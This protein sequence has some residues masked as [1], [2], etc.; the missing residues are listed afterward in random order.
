MA[1]EFDDGVGLDVPPRSRGHVVDDLWQ[2]DGVRDR[3]VVLEQSALLG[4]VVVRRDEQQAVGTRVGG[5]FGE[6]ERLA[7]IVRSRPGDDGDVVDGLDD[8]LDDLYVFVVGQGRRL[9]G[10]AD[11]NES[12]DA[13]GS[14]RWA[15]VRSVSKSIRSASSKGVH[16]AGKTP[17][18]SRVELMCR[19][20]SWVASPARS[21][22]YRCRSA[23]GYWNRSCAV[24]SSPR[25]VAS[26]QRAHL[27]TFTFEKTRAD[28]THDG[29]GD[30]VSGE[31]HVRWTGPIRLI[32]CVFIPTGPR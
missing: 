4:L 12:V 6:F 1:R 25:R 27:R 21:A 15:S 14:R 8:R 16:I 22:A 11:G 18:R 26:P 2:V 5:A 28:A 29:T 19:V 24:E 30:R 10:R 9:A 31:T 3:S 13:R 17:E 32:S 23:G 7:R 20:V